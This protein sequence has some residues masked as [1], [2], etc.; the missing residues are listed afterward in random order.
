M[1][2]KINQIDLLFYYFYEKV[3]NFNSIN[4]QNMRYKIISTK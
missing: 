3:N 4:N 2:L 1:K